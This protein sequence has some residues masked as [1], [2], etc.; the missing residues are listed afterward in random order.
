M[1]AMN[2]RG[3]GHSRRE[4]AKSCATAAAAP[5]L[6]GTVAAEEPSKP[7]P[8][9]QVAIDAMMEIVRARYGKQLTEEQL[10]EVQR[11]IVQNVF[12]AERMKK[13]KLANSDEPAFIFR[14]EV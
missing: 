14:A 4:F 12:I 5:F 13:F 11:G 9:P 10:K 3:R 1:K 8:V 7:K 6:A 2:Q